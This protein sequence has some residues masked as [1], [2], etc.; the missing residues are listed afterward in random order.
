[1]AS[2][3][4]G[5]QG[6]DLALTERL[7][8]EV[9]RAVQRGLK[10]MEML[11]VSTP[12]VGRTPKT[13]LH[14]RGTL[15]LVHYRAVVDEVYRVPL[16]VVMAPTNKGYI[17]DLAPG[18]S[19][20]GFLL[21]R[22]Y[23]VY[24]IDWNAPTDDERELKIDDYVL[25]FIPDC[26][27]RVQR[28]S[29]E[30]EVTLLGYC[31]GGMLSA[32]YQSLHA[33][34]PV[35]NLVCMTTPVDFSK[36]ELFR[37]LADERSFDVDRFVDGVGVVPAD[38]V[39][40]TFDALR[41]AS[42][43]A[44]QVRL[45]DNLWNDRFVKGYRMM[46]RW[47]NET[48]PLPGGYFRQTTQELLQKNALYEG[49]LRIG[50]RRVDLDKITVPLLHIVAQYDHIVPPE[51]ARPLVERVGSADK[52]EVVLPGGH[53]SIAAGANAVKRMWPKLDSWLEG[54]SI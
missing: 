49:T 17:L 25:D 37:S 48:L 38:F 12:P 35:K 32:I 31:A 16:L 30:H 24:L 52:E 51:C 3:S 14:R 39:L 26:I 27:R 45:W 42:R 13:V 40:A 43:I 21:E 9:E 8:L 36:M 41:P 4:T 46:E 6:A 29:G 15:E 47:G 20:I 34:G 7:Q 1:M 10:S 22:G 44:G 2:Q 53:V 11:G 33:D 18:Q 23:D 5:K 28:D 19:L 54:R 50:G